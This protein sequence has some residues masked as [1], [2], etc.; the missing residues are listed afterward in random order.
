MIN[1]REAIDFNNNSTV[2]NFERKVAA[3]AG[4]RYA[5]L[6]SSGRSAIRFSLLALRTKNSDEIIIPDLS[7]EILPITVVCSRMTPRFC[8]IE[9][10]T[11]ALS[12]ETLAKV[13]NK[14]TKAVILV[15]PY[16]IPVDPSPIQEITKKNGAMLI[17]DASQALG[18]GVNNKKVGSFGDVGIFS[19]Y[20]FLNVNSGGIALTD[21]LQIANLIR[22]NRDKFEKSSFFAV[23]LFSLTKLFSSNS[24]MLDAAFD[25]DN[26]YGKFRLRHGRK[27]FDI[28]NGRLIANKRFHKLPLSQLP[29]NFTINQLMGY[30][31]PHIR[32]KLEELEIK[33]LGTS[34]D[35]LE[36]YLQERRKIIKMYEDNLIDK[37][38]QKIMIPKNCSPSYFRYPILINEEKKRAEIIEKIAQKGFLVDSNYAPLHTSSSALASENTNLKFSK[39]IYA[40]KHLIPLPVSKRI[41]QHFSR[42]PVTLG[43]HFLPH[44][45]EV[46]A[47]PKEIMEI[48]SIANS[49]DRLFHLSANN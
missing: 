31:Q 21:N 33:S 30:Y 2:E 46:S 16:G 10:E 34:F 14:N 15:H 49:N 1:C 23:S 36:K 11:L 18:A 8:D 12:T 47:N 38:L 40:S 5:I 35:G 32:R 7:C 9:N 37:G 4:T 19:F 20:K 48:I 17:E 39:S 29:R 3:Y 41:I 45:A 28:N 26:F 43:K 13:I 24:R 22:I 6:C 44:C 25:M 42:L 27:D